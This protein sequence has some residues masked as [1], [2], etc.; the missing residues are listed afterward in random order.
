MFKRSHRDL[1][2][3]TRSIDGLLAFVRL[4]SADTILHNLQNCLVVDNLVQPEALHWFSRLKELDG[5][6]IIKTDGLLAIN[7]DY[8]PRRG[9]EQFPEEM[10]VID[11]AAIKQPGSPLTIPPLVPPAYRR[12]V[13]L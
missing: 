5:K 13:A 10:L 6:L 8:R 2:C 4:V 7:D 12:V 1:P 11:G 9:L 3:C